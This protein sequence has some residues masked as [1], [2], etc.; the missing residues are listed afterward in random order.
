MTN[1][2]LDT[3]FRALEPADG[4]AARAAA[5]AR[6]VA[7]AF[8]ALEDPGR[9][10]GVPSPAQL[11]GAEAVAAPLRARLRTLVARPAASAGARPA[12]SKPLILTLPAR[13]ERGG[14]CFGSSRS[15]GPACT[16]ACASGMC[17]TSAGALACGPWPW[18]CFR[19]RPCCRGPPATQRVAAW[20]PAVR[21][22]PRRLMGCQ[23]RRRGRAGRRRAPVALGPLGQ[24]RR[25][26]R[27]VRGRRHAH[28]SGPACGR[29]CHRGILQDAQARRTSVPAL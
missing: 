3:L 25:T 9:S 23:R 5:A 21:C 17:P 13:R 8:A 1:G 24:R 26:V 28:A 7:A 19:L 16:S 20:R 11:I 4:C 18:R 15:A 10:L 22:S 14:H 6:G 12:R 27:R 2:L 29:R